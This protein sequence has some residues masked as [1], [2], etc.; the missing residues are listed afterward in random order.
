VVAM[1][2]R[3]KRILI[4]D[5]SETFLMY[6]SIL[7]RRMGFN[8]VIPANSGV[9]ALKL[10][11]MMMPDVVLLDIAMPQMDGVTILRHIKGDNHTSNIPVIMA[12]I[13]SDS[14]SYEECERL[15]CS[16]YLTK[17]VKLTELNDTLNRC[18]S[19]AGG[20]KRRF[21]RTSFKKKVAITCN[22]V[23]EEQYAENLSQRGIYI[24][25]RNPFN[26]GTEVEIALP[27]KGGKTVN[28]EGTV[29]YIKVFSEDISTNSPGM[30]IEFKELISNDSEM[31]RTYIA[32]LLTKDII[33][34]QDEPIIKKDY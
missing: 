19:Y 11:R 7:L 10:L 12:T 15:G 13:V 14:K 6:I 23:T 31:L 3:S 27:L 17:P 30:G 16:G 29:I 22:G 25:K 32:E 33:E 24:R 8:K 20:K 5:D 18:I 26:V 4:V 2:D 28:L 9:E 21:L 1:D 34:E